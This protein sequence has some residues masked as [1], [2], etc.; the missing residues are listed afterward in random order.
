MHVRPRYA[1]RSLQFLQ[2]RASACHATRHDDYLDGCRWMGELNGLAR[3]PK[4]DKEKEPEG[5]TILETI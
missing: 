5:E 4:Q 2:P 1:V 3:K